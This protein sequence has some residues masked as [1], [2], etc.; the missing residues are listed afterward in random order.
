MSADTRSDVIVIGA[1]LGG[2]GAGAILARAGHEVRLLERAPFL[3]GRIRVEERNGCLIDYGIHISRFQNKGR[4]AAAVKAAGGSPVFIKPGE[5]LA[6]KN[7]RMTKI[8][9]GPLGFMETEIMSPSSKMRIGFMILRMILRNQR[10]YT[11][12]SLGEIVAAHNPPPDIM[13]MI[14]IFA[15]S[16]LAC[17]DVNKLAAKEVKQFMQGAISS[18]IHLFGYPKGGYKTYIDLMRKRIESHGEILTR[19]K[20]EKV[21]VRDGKAVGVEAGGETYTARAVVCNAPFQNVLDII[22][23]RHLGPELADYARRVEPTSGIVLDFILNRPVSKL[24][25]IVMTSEPATM[26]CMISNMDPSLAP[27]GKQLG[28]WFQFVPYEKTKDREYIKRE[29][30]GLIELVGKMFPGIWE[31]CEWKRTITA[32]LVDGAML[33]V[34]QT[35]TERA[36]LVAPKAENLF[37]VGDTTCGVGC[38]GDIA[39]D[40]AVRVSKLADKYLRGK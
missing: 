32:P 2:L 23:A 29:S 38:G 36:P 24:A 5:P 7:G 25:S 15:Q 35:W 37:F 27:H 21:I 1:G 9:R 33:K 6:F 31:A 22:D 28:T 26:G 34:G 12:K 18:A 3:G 4:Y 8:P 30:E 17:P 13:E 20:V 11:E 16:A 19:T 14:N 39:L 40:S 10:D